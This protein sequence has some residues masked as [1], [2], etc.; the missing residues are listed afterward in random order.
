MTAE[1]MEIIIAGLPSLSKS[2]LKRKWAQLFG[3]HCYSEGRD[4]LIRRI[5]WRLRNEYKGGLSDRAQERAKLICDEALIR[6]RPRQYQYQ[7][8]EDTPQQQDSMSV[9]KREYKGEVHEVI[10]LSGGRY[11]YQGTIYDNLT[12]VAWK[13]AGYKTSGN[14]FFNLPSKPRSK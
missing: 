14:K 8:Q 5:T 1:D 10:V 13:I 6:L 9:I 12:S 4:F 7:Q 2:E 11:A 3:T